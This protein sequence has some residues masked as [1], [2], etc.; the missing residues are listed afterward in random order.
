[1]RSAFLLFLCAVAT[2]CLAP[3]GPAFNPS[4]PI[5]P[6][7]K[8]INRALEYALDA[9]SNLKAVVAVFQTH[10]GEQRW[11][12]RVYDDLVDATTYLGMYVE[13]VGILRGLI[14]ITM[15]T[16]SQHEACMASFKA[17]QWWPRCNDIV[18][19]SIATILEQEYVVGF[20]TTWWECGTCETVYYRLREVRHGVLDDS[21]QELYIM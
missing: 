12:R 4:I 7:V 8:V 21:Y 18:G 14:N 3:C 10:A 17:M 19:R 1:M 13:Q 9:E 11:K 2:G 16:E 5:M 20:W 15:S 6:Y